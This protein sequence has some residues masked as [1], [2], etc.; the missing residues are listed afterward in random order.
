MTYPF[1][2]IVTRCLLVLG[3]LALVSSMAWAQGGRGEL[4]G[5]VT[6]PSDAVV[7]GVTAT[8]TNSATGDK[9]TT[10]T[11]PAGTYRFVALPI[12]TYTLELAPKGFKSVKVTDVVISVGI[13]NTRDIK[14]ELGS[15]TEQVTVEAG[16]QLV[17]TNDAAL[18]GL[19]DRRVWQQLP[20][21]NRDTNA[22]IN[23]LA[24]AVQGNVA[25]GMNGG[26]DRGAAVNGTRSGTGNY[27]VEGFDNNDQGLGGGGSFGNTGGSSTTISPDAIQEYRV[28]EHNFAAEYGRAGGFVTDTVLRSGTNQWHGSLFEYNR[29]QALAANSFFSN[30]ND[31]KDSLVRNQF[32]GSVGGPII[33]DKTFFFFA[34]EFQR[35]RS[36]NPLSGNVLTRD[37]IN[38]VDSGGFQTWAESDPTGICVT[39]TANP[40]PGTF[41]NSGTIGPIFRNLMGSQPMLV[42]EPGAANC[43]NPTNV[44]TGL[45]T[46]G[47]TYPVNEFAFITVPQAFKLDQARYSV[48]LDHR[49]SNS[50]QLTGTYTYDNADALSQWEGGSSTFGPDLSN[51]GRAMV[52]GIVWSHT[53]SPTILNQARISFNRRTANFPGDQSATDAGIPALFTAFDAYQGSFGNAGNLPQFFTENQFQYKDDL[54]VTKGK[55]NFKAGAEYRRIRNGSSFQVDPFGTFSAYGIED[56]ITDFAFGDNAD[57]A[58]IGYPYYGSWFYAEAAI[59]PTKTPATLP[60]YY[61]GFRAN[62]FAAYFQDDWRITPRLTLNLGLRWDYFGPPHNFKSNIDSNYYLGA[63]VTPIQTTSNNPFFP[64]NDPVLAS[65]ATGSLQVRNAEIWNKDTNNFAPRFGFAWDT[66]G[67]QKFVVRGGAGVAYDRMYNNIFENIRFNPPFFCFCNFGAFINN[68]PGGQLSTPGLYEV[69]FN[70]QGLFND[71]IFLPVLPKTS[72]RAIDQNLVAAY[73]EQFNFGFQYELMRDFVLESN[74]VGTFGRKLVGIVNLNTFPGRSGAGFLGTRLN[75]DVNNINLRTNAFASN[76]NA[77][78]TTLRKRFSYGLQFNANYTYAKALD[79]ISDTFTPRGVPG[80]LNPTDS[81]NVGLD[82]GPADFDVKHRFVFSYSY[83]LPFFKGNRWLGGWSTSGTVSLQTGVPFSITNAGVDS[84]RNGTFNDREAFVGSGSIK[85]VLTGGSPAGNADGTGGYFDTTAFL[86]LNSPGGDPTETVL[87]PADVNQGLWCQ[88]VAFGQTR[89]N[90][91][92][93]PNFQNIDFGVAKRFKIT[94]SAAFT[95]QANFFNLFNR[96]NFAQVVGNA[97]D[98]SNFGR[99]T[100]TYEPGNGGARVTQLALRFDF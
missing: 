89:R 67:N 42:C 2:R 23:L 82:Y 46:F 74:W 100:A 31:V 44:G 45:Y 83:D 1:C 25:F 37:F 60:D 3:V 81:L 73:Y 79:Q 24:G 58:V 69:P 65:F 29:V 43:S 97:N 77:W 68:I 35:T 36:K 56:L 7:S 17:Q 40:C 53:F 84:N 70:N 21:E 5:L 51:H 14:L 94:E 41:A 33:K 26:T 49:V 15:T 22:F 75:P 90:T 96:A 48:K 92:Y 6:D 39:Y 19:V 76:Y 52:T 64:V 18:S 57:T 88:G 71:P 91:L 93:G 55:H 27:L 12:G 38:F 50:D 62:E 61:R 72:P 54:A 34:T 20:L 4:T 59:D 16:A 78:Q 28:I 63:P 13:V 8:L 98:S 47:L 86:P 11:T 80:N 66:F 99:A 87:C 30:R 32:G 10:V 9:R 95:F 85:S